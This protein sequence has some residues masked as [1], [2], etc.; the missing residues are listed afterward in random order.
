MFKL[1]TG[2]LAVVTACALTMAGGP[3]LATGKSSRHLAETVAVS[4]KVVGGRSSLA[5]RG[6]RLA[7]KLAI[8]RFEA[9][10]GK[11]WAVGR[12]ESRLAG[13][14]FARTVRFRVSVA[15]L[16]QTAQIPPTPNACTILSLTLQPLDINLLGLRIRTSRI[17]VL[18]EGVRGPGNLLGNLLCGLTGILNPSTT[19]AQLNV[20]QVAQVLNAVLALSPLQ[21]TA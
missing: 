3:G 20:A 16:A 12:L 14:S 4:G 19:G 11:L 6:D 9:R 7:A 8:V 17:D 21:T 5:S 18:I 10:H 13:R 15:G 1:R 2:A